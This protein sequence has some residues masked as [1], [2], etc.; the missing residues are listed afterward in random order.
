MMDR[1]GVTIVPNT[2]VITQP[3]TKGLEFLFNSKGETLRWR[4]VREGRKFTRHA[5]GGYSDHIPV[6]AQFTVNP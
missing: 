4:S 2:Y 1:R 6:F 5:P 3:T